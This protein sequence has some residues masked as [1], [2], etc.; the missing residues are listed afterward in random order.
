VTH[1]IYH[2]KQNDGDS[3]FRTPRRVLKLI[4][5]LPLELRRRFAAER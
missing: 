1:D 3:A 4:E 2:W 5:D